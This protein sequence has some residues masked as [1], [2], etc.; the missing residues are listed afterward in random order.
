MCNGMCV[1]GRRKVKKKEAQGEK[2]E[3]NCV[4]ICVSENTPTKATYRVQLALCS[5]RR[6]LKGPGKRSQ[7]RR[8]RRCRPMPSAQ[9]S[10]LHL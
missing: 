2:E 7:N 8:R 1:N 9:Y 3:A 6:F 4:Y 5:L 10:G